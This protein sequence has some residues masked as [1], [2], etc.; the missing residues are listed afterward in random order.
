[1]GQFFGSTRSRAW[2]N[3]HVD[4][5]VPCAHQH[6]QF[7][8]RQCFQFFLVHSTTFYLILS[9]IESLQYYRKLQVLH[10]SNF[11]VVW[12]RIRYDILLFTKFWVFSLFAVL[13]FRSSHF[14]FLVFGH[15][16][17]WS[18]ENTEIFCNLCWNFERQDG[19]DR[20]TPARK[21]CN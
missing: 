20:K 8:S 12:M 21:S 10:S 18:Y 17:W 4:H 14:S 5:P 19:Q 9:W 16:W 15:F 7:R 2:S 6:F 1:M 3:G 13:L 11:F